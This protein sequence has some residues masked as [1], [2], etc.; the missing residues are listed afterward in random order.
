VESSEQ[1]FTQQEAAFA[2]NSAA[3]AAL[4]GG[5]QTLN[6]TL[7]SFQELNKTADVTSV[8]AGAQ[9]SAQ[10]NITTTTS[11]P[12]NVV[13][14]AQGGGDIAKAVGEAVQNAIPTIIE[15][16]RLAMGEKVPPTTLQLPNINIK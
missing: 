3:I 16:V 14:N 7:S 12:V 2:T 15:K 13:V 4:T 5:I 8:G 1:L 6:A 11:A 10:P 9:T